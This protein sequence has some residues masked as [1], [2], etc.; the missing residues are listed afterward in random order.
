MVVSCKY[1]LL[2]A[3]V[4]A[5]G[6]L[7]GFSVSSLGWQYANRQAE[8]TPCLLF[9]CFEFPFHSSGF[10][11]EN[12]E[13]LF[14]Y[15]FLQYQFFAMAVQRIYYRAWPLL[16]NLF[17]TMFVTGYFTQ[18][19]WHASRDIPLARHTNAR[20]IRTSDCPSLPDSIGILWC[21]GP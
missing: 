4:F 11:S 20:G 15:T 1:R 16:C 14:K 7:E 2:R 5:C 21:S 10:K 12:I 18:L 13:G 19:R 9:S 8:F 17:F 3:C 6:S